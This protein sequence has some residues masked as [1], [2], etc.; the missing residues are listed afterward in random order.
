VKPLYTI[1]SILPNGDENYIVSIR[2]DEK[3]V[4]F[5]FT[6]SARGRLNIIQAQ[7]EA[8]LSVRRMVSGAQHVRRLRETEYDAG[9]KIAPANPP[10]LAESLFALIAP[11]AS[12]ETQLGDLQEL[13]DSQVE[14]YG[15]SRARRFYWMQVIRAVGPRV[16]RALTKWGFIGALVEFGR[17]KL[18]L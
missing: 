16:W 5:E 12:A 18:G 8:N 2:I 9:R 4:Q 14:R 15:L 3:F 11:T 6:P 10:V 7:A 13:F 17:R 1:E